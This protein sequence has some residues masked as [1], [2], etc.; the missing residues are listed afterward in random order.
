MNESKI[1]II[2]RKWQCISYEI[3]PY[4]QPHNFFATDFT[5]R[6]NLRLPAA[7]K[8]IIVNEVR[9]RILPPTYIAVGLSRLQLGVNS[10][11]GNENLMNKNFIF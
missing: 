3:Q 7:G 1:E 2:V 11:S 4:C 9:Q 6:G 5:E 10:R 8:P